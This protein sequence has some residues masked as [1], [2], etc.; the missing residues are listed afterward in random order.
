MRLH[1]YEGL[2][3]FFS[4]FFFKWSLVMTTLCMSF[5][6]FLPSKQ[7]WRTQGLISPGCSQSEMSRSAGYTDGWAAASCE[8][9]HVQKA[10]RGA[11]GCQGAHF[12]GVNP[13]FNDI[14]HQYERSWWKWEP[15][16]KSLLHTRCLFYAN[17]LHTK[18][19]QTSGCARM[20]F[21][22][23]VNITLR[24]EVNFFLNFCT[25]NNASTNPNQK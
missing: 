20:A 10:C 14:R 1:F 15:E 12:V 3:F 21:I 7:Y 8:R 25:A 24:I 22:K 17:T 23:N 6:T 2:L 4:F 9:C 19:I 13:Y 18:K 16:T 11:A 5:H